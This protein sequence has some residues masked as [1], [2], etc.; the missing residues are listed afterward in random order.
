VLLVAAA[1][2]VDFNYY[3]YRTYTHP[4]F[5]W[6]QGARQVAMAQALRRRGPGW[7]AYLL[8]PRFS[9]EYE[10]MRFLARAWN[11]NFSDVRALADIA[12]L[13]DVPAAG[14][15]FATNPGSHEAGSLLRRFYTDATAQ[16]IEDPAPRSWFFG[17]DWPYKPQVAHREPVATLIAVSRDELERARARRG[18]RW[19]PAR[20]EYQ[21]R[22]GAVILR[23]EP[24]PFF[25]FF[26]D[27]FAE[28]F[29]ARF[30]TAI[31]VPPPG[32]YALEVRGG[33]SVEMRIDGV[34]L[35]PGQALK[36]GRHVIDLRLPHVARRL[37]LWVWWTPPGGAP[38][39]VPADAWRPLGLREL[40]PP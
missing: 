39:P 27:T 15:L 3:F 34:P 30:T 25:N 14:V 37:R 29:T 18:P 24:P 4:D 40:P 10:T 19:L 21:L 20:A 13:D 23:R 2:F 28:S 6:M 17:G 11:L 12:P 36:G 9:A 16:D 38:P 33:E 35:A 32:G 31:F 5:R 22:D 1:L 8:S 26:A 7:R